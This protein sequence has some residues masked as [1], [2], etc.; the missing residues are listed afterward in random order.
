M[1]TIRV[2]LHIESYARLK[3]LKK[4]AGLTAQAIMNNAIN[5]TYKAQLLKFSGKD[6]QDQG[7]QA[8]L[9][10]DFYPEEKKIK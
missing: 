10:F 8:T 9:D 6:E 3:W 2:M 7:I 1:K 5:E 4:N